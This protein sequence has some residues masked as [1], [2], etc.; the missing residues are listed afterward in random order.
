MEN[1]ATTSFSTSF[2]ASTLELQ[3]LG[4]C[5]GSVDNDDDRLTSLIPC[6]ALCY[7]SARNAGVGFRTQ[8]DFLLSYA[9][10]LPFFSSVLKSFFFGLTVSLFLYDDLITII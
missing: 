5:F 1:E 6:Q 2:T 9:C 10:V 4:L 3:C 7:E 8:L